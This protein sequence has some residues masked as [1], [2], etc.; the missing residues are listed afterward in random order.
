MVITHKHTQWHRDKWIEHV[1]MYPYML[2]FLYMVFRE[3]LLEASQ[4]RFPADPLF[5]RFSTRRRRR[6]R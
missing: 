2:S 1:Q 6:Y 4:G 5:S 3:R